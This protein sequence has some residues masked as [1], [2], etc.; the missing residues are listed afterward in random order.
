LAPVALTPSKPAA[1]ARLKSQR[2]RLLNVGL[3]SFCAASLSLIA[4]GDQLSLSAEPVA[5]VNFR[6]AAAPLLE[7]P[8]TLSGAAMGPSQQSSDNRAKPLR[9]TLPPV[10][11]VVNLRDLK[12]D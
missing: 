12:V 9:I 7:V 8:A 5:A 4:L 6:T 11:I 10:K 3:A 2:G 1:P